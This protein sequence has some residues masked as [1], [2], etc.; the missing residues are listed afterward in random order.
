MARWSKA[1][2]LTA[3]LSCW[4]RV[5]VESPFHVK[6]FYKFKACFKAAHVII[7]LKT[8]LVNLVDINCYNIYFAVKR[9]EKTQQSMHCLESN[10]WVDYLHFFVSPQYHHLQSHQHFGVLLVINLNPLSISSITMK[11][12]SRVRWQ[13]TT[14]RK[15]KINGQGREVWS[16]NLTNVMVDKH[17]PDPLLETPVCDYSV[18]RHDSSFCLCWRLVSI[19]L[20]VPV[21]PW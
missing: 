17:M 18:A 10:T 2:Q 11:S 20:L 14:G 16:T 1:L 7:Q 13:L 8:F 4:F 21:R 3:H 19:T 12:G 6:P 15:E 9:E 5:Y